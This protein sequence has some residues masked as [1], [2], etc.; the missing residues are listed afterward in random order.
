MSR[1]RKTS[2]VELGGGLNLNIALTYL[3]KHAPKP[4]NTV[5]TINGRG[6]I[7]LNYAKRF[8]CNFGLEELLRAN[9]VLEA[10]EEEGIVLAEINVSAI[11]DFRREESWR[12][13]YRKDWYRSLRTL[14]Q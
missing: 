6:E 13:R 8:I 2:L 14:G 5:S 3:E 4:R 12:M 7:V 11:R 10:G 9:P 1:S